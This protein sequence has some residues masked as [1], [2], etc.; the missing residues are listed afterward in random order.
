MVTTNEKVK[1]I[2]KIINGGYANEFIYYELRARRAPEA[3]V[4]LPRKVFMRLVD[5][6]D[7]F[8]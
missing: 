6:V 8:H 2:E 3:V 4:M 1:H 7:T 5:Y